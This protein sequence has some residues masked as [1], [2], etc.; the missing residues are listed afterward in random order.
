MVNFD[1]TVKVPEPLVLASSLEAPA[2]EEMNVETA[3][4]PHV[5]GLA[6]PVYFVLD[7]I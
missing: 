6:V 5:P 3:A 2:G 4:E 1:N 7:E